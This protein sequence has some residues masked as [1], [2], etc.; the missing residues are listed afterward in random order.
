MLKALRISASALSAN[1]KKM[2]AVS[3]NIANS[4][5]T[6]T[7]E[8]GP[9]RKKE[10]VFG[11]EPSR[12]SFAEILD[13]EVDGHLQEVHATEVINSNKPPIAKY[14]PNNPDA[15]DQGYVYYPN[16][17]TMEEMADM[18]STQRNYE[19]NVSALNTAKAMASKALEIG[20]GN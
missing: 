3:S 16:I 8:G 9:Y 7:A 2:E 20:R 4:Q 5:T 15:D 6:R 17:N 12:E 18:I 11:A 14:E 10:V 19:A 1:R 13:G